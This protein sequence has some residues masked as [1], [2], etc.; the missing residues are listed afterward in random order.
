ME[1]ER[2][3]LE[4]V[5]EGSADAF[6]RL[7]RLHHARVR[8]Y[9]G[10]SLTDKSVVDDLAQEVFFSAYRTLDSFKGDAPLG[11]WLIGIARNRLLTYLR[12][13]ARRQEH[14]MA[15]KKAIAEWQTSEIGSRAPDE[16]D[17]QIRISALSEC[18]KKLGGNSAALIEGFYFKGMSSTDLSRQMAKE[19]GV[20]RMTIRRIRLALRR[21]IEQRL[22]LEKA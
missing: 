11:T 4:A 1:D 16:R 17:E 8:A 19:A 15:L 21:C 20:L 12:T 13:E 10:C 5:R 18:V 2:G 9:L 3:L 6:A 22:A 14:N 7:V